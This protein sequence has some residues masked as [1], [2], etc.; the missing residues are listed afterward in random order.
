MGISFS[1]SSFNPWKRKADGTG[2]ETSENI[3]AKGAEFDGPV[4]I[5]TENLLQ[6]PRFVAP[7]GY[8][9]PTNYL[10]ISFFDGN[11]GTE[12]TNLAT[13]GTVSDDATIYAK[14]SKGIRTANTGTASDAKINKVPSPAL[15]LSTYDSIVLRFFVAD[16]LAGAGSIFIQLGSSGSDYVRASRAFDTA[17]LDKPVRPGWNRIVLSKASDFGDVTGTMNWAAVNNIRVWTHNNEGATIAVTWDEL[18]AVKKSL[19][20][21]VI[22]FTFDDGNISDFTKAKPALD[23]Y[24][25]R[26]TSYI[27]GAWI[28]APNYLSASQIQSLYHE[29]GWDIGS[30]TYNHVNLTTLTT[31]QVED[32]LRRNIYTLKNLGVKNVSSIAYPFGGYSPTVVDIVKKYHSAGRTVVSGYEVFPFGNPYALRQVQLTTGIS[33]VTAK[34][35]IDRAKANCEVVIYLAHKIVDSGA[36][37]GEWTTSDFTALVNYAASEGLEVLSLAELEWKYGR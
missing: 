27:I 11:L 26:A 21:G 35:Y 14:G 25:Y 7:V 22:V 29:C 6:P 13:G 33:L 19:S 24:G 8:T 34:T 30:H 5:G 31:D 9:D 36:A 32:E 16:T 18:A 20:K 15:D 37:G 1:I 28:E 3:K 17:L 12:W 2:I 23:K 10:R 4:S